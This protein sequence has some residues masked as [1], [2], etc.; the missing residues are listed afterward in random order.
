VAAPIAA[1]TAI[2]HGERNETAPLAAGA[3]RRTADADY[4]VSRCKAGGFH[5]ACG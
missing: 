5:A 1:F 4:F 3:Q 2:P